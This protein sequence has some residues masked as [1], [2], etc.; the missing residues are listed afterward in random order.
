MMS[1]PDLSNFN[2]IA[3]LRTADAPSAEESLK[4]GSL[5]LL[6][7]A[8]QAGRQIM[9][10]ALDN[11]Y[12]VNIFETP[13]AE[14]FF[15]DSIRHPESTNE[16]WLL[17]WLNTPDT[18]NIADLRKDYEQSYNAMVKGLASRHQ[19]ELR[20]NCAEITSY[21]NRLYVAPPDFPAGELWVP[22]EYAVKAPA[23]S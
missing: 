6:Y 1:Q 9:T 12:R 15:L 5:S 13:Y 10:R 3:W 20:L 11:I 14:T 22:E 18:R 4:I 2:Q 21:T 23:T 17:T 16:Y 19:A 8:L 7:I